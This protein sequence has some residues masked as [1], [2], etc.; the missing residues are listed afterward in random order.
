MN[1]SRKRLKLAS[2]STI[3]FH[4][5]KLKEG[6]YLGKTENKARAISVAS[7]E[8]MI[9]IPFLGIIAA[10]EPIEAIRQDEFIAVPKNILPSTGNLY[11]L[12]VSG[13]SMIDENIQDGDVVLVK[14]QNVAE[15][16]R[17]TIVLLRDY[18]KRLKKYIKRQ[19]RIELQKNK[20]I[21]ARKKCPAC[22]QK[23]DSDGR[24]KCTNKDAW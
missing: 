16:R 13:N 10:G 12:R 24:C 20:K 9:K 18:K 11:D 8:P 17:A 19:K 22:R 15:K 2:V 4:I 6:G 1:I 21:L 14:Q 5:S 23:E 3:H 7:K